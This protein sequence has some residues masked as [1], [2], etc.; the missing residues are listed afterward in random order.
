MLEIS[1]LNLRLKKIVFT[2]AFNLSVPQYKC[3]KNKYIVEDLLLSIIIRNINQKKKENVHNVKQ[4]DERIITRCTNQLYETK[5]YKAVV[6][7]NTSH[8]NNT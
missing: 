2:L 8:I 1:L 5:Q 7:I 4:Y 6:N 3:K